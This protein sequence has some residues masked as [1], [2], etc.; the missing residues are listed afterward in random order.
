MTPAKNHTR[1]FGE[2]I[3]LPQHRHTHA[4]KTPLTTQGDLEFLTALEAALDLVCE[5]PY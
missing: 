1:I 4:V 3:I 5:N 2:E